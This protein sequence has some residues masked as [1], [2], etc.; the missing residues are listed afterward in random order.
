[1]AAYSRIETRRQKIADNRQTGKL[2][3][4]FSRGSVVAGNVFR[5]AFEGPDLMSG[6][7]KKVLDI[8]IRRNLGV[9][10]GV[11]GSIGAAQR[12]RLYYCQASDNGRGDRK[13]VV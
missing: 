12:G 1:M 6:K 2:L 7:V 8:Y 13:S 9:E 5:L 10:N 4:F 3:R 11:D